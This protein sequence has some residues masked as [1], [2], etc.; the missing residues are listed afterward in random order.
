MCTLGVRELKN[1][2]KRVFIATETIQDRRRK[3]VTMALRMEKKNA[4][5]HIN[6]CVYKYANGWGILS[7]TRNKFWNAN[8]FQCLYFRV[9]EFSF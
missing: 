4:H 9:M 2:R 3:T 5:T 6:T 1:G 7:I 8:I